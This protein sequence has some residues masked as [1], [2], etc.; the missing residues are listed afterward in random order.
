[1]T[2]PSIFACRD[3]RALHWQLGPLPPAT[4]RLLLLGW[5]QSAARHDAGVPDDVAN[6]L[7]RALTSV[8]RATFPCSVMSPAATDGWSEM[9]GDLIRALTGRSVAGRIAAKLKGTPPDITLVSTRRPETAISLFHDAGFPW[10]LQG[11]VALLSTPEA[12][13]PE[14][15][16]ESLLALTGDDWTRRAGSFDPSAAVVGVLRPGV[17]GDVAGLLSLTEVFERFVLTALESEA[18][19]ADFDWALLPEEAFALR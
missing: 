6:I 3:A 15:D 5:S 13:L 18:R 14:I 19:R 8:A 16:Q 11:Q 9:D 12:P 7:A 2:R 1:V 10:W 17:D 4:G